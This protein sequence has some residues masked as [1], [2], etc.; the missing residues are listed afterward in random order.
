MQNILSMKTDDGVSA[1]ISLHFSETCIPDSVLV[2]SLT[3]ALRTLD[4]FFSFH[5]DSPPTTDF[6]S[7]EHVS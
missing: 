6:L 5:Y 7:N 1:Q 4:Y 2:H 3:T